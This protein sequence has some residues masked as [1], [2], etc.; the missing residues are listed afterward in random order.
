MTHKALHVLPS[1]KTMLNSRCSVGYSISLFLRCWERVSVLN[2]RPQRQ[3]WKRGEGM[4]TCPQ[5]SFIHSTCI[6]ER[7]A[8]PWHC[9]ARGTQSPCLTEFAFSFGLLEWSR[10]LQSTVLGWEMD[11][12]LGPG[13]PDPVTPQ[14]FWSQMR[15]WVAIVYCLRHQMPNVC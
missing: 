12:L 9:E 7:S 15:H 1:V 3:E 6:P 14:A 4:G 10:Q 5:P 8:G 13:S 11:N 2:F